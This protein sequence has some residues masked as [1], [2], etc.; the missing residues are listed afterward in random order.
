VIVASS[1]RYYG[2][3][4]DYP[5]CEPGGDE[6][7]S[8]ALTEALLMTKVLA[9]DAFPVWFDAYLPRVAEV[10]RSCNRLTYRIRPTRRSPTWM[11]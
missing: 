8:G 7:I 1:L 6:F 3:D 5:H 11:A 10:F 4:T 2:K 9:E